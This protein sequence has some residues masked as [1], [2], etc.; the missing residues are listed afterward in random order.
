MILPIIEAVLSQVVPRPP[1]Q[2]SADTDMAVA[3][4]SGSPDLKRAEG[5]YFQDCGLIIRADDTLFRV[6][7]QYLATHSAFFRDM[8]SIPV[9]ADAEKID[10]CL[11][12]AVSDSAG[13][14]A[15][16]LRGIM[17]PSFFESPPAAVTFEKLRPVLR[18][19]HKYDVGWLQR[20][21]LAHLARTHPTTL[22]D[23]YTLTAMP[24]SFV[25]G[26]S[27]EL[28]IEI[29]LIA[30][31]FRLE[32]LLPMA[33]YRLTRS[34]SSLP[35]LASDLSL[36]DK[37]R[38]GD[39]V[40]KLDLE[41]RTQA[42]DF[43]WQPRQITQCTKPAS[44]AAACPETRLA[45]RKRTEQMRESP[46]EQYVMPLDL[47]GEAWWKAMADMHVC[48]GCLGEMR[49]LKRLA[50]EAFWEAL[51]RIFDLGDWATLEARKAQTFS[52][53]VSG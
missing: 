20:R 49:R 48:G 23:W 27:A 4:T 32:W 19:S 47:W 12:V 26:A 53:D 35:V 43:L 24:A 6:S 15:A 13:D 45:Y 41:W 22:D 9:P 5:L 14:M 28:C 36:A 11:V 25:N 2:M 51:P 34:K 18:L 21:A 42:L 44:P 7:G 37:R 50:D 16:F 33:F 30:R 29:I 38:W 40:R 46:K 17:Y 1:P 3:Q 10:G 39:A 31:D 8:L 52:E